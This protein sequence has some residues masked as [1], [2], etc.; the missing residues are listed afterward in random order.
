[1]ALTDVRTGRPDAD[2]D[3]RG[4]GVVEDGR[5]EGRGCDVESQGGREGTG[6]SLRCTWFRDCGCDLFDGVGGTVR[7]REGPSY[8]QYKLCYDSPRSSLYHP[9]PMTTPRLSS[10]GKTSGFPTC[11]S[12][13]RQDRFRTS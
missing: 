6:F 10:S 12:A 9:S 7:S 13:A 4:E 1:M 2:E 3:S 11:G 8:C 5:L